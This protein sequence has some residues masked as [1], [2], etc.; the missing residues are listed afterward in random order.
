MS[1]NAVGEQAPVL[2]IAT[3]RHTLILALIFLI[4]AAAGAYSR[5]RV[6]IAG[7]S[8]SSGSSGPSVYLSVIVG[9]L[10][11]I[12][13]V[14]RGTR[15]NVSAPIATL[16]GPRWEN[17]GAFLRDVL[18][19]AALWGAWLGLE[20]VLSR[21]LPSTQGAS[22]SL[23]PVGTLNQSLWVTLS[24]IAGIAEEIV[25]RG[26]FMRQMHALTGRT[27]AA[28]LLQA[29][30][31]SVAHGYQGV[32]ACV[33]IAGFGILF[34]LVALWRRNLRACIIAHAWTD[35]AAGLLRI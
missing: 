7:A 5:A 28:L 14:W 1:L 24:I 3:K 20:L 17:V 27:W 29:A 2:P 10:A 8:P 15:R 30:L 35:I 19:A 16:I 21:V 26:Y 12:Y 23:L 31:F 9:E 32:S 18:L 33:K 22:E 11:L 6:G 25:F 34:G 4:V 13:Y